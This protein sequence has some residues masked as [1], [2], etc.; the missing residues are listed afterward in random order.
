MRGDRR[1]RLQ[2]KLGGGL[3]LLGQEMRRL[4]AGA[5][6]V[7]EYHI[8]RVCVASGLYDGEMAAAGNSTVSIS[9]GV[10]GGI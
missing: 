4:R 1:H 5:E 2:E 3:G 9:A 8:R 10:R 6:C 7:Q